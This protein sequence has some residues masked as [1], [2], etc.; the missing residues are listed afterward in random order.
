ML[1]VVRVGSAVTMDRLTFIRSLQ[2]AA[3]HL[4]I[5]AEQPEM[6]PQAAEM[7]ELAARLQA[8]GA[9]ISRSETAECTPSLAN[10]KCRFRPRIGRRS[11]PMERVPRQ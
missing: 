7:R 2:G 6:R 8:L 10:W 5:H 1:A 11:Q 3:A 4:L 9:R